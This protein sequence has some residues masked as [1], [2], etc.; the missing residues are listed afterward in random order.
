MSKR[1]ISALLS[2]SLSISMVLSL[3]SF[4]AEAIIWSKH[5]WKLEHN[6]DAFA[7]DVA[8]ACLTTKSSNIST[9]GTEITLQD[10]KACGDDIQTL[11][12]T[13][14]KD[15]NVQMA[16]VNTIRRDRKKMKAALTEKFKDSKTT[17]LTVLP[18]SNCPC[19]VVQ[20]SR[21]KEAVAFIHV[22]FGKANEGIIPLK[23]QLH[24]DKSNTPSP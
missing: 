13:W 23:F 20:G 21:A 18:K 11:S 2:I 1:S 9:N 8:M 12:Q 5:T 19:L 3:F 22:Q 4:S 6:P 10:D 7:H 14:D 17:E 15:P 16:S 24:P